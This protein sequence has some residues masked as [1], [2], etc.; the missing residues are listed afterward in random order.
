MKALNFNEW[1][2]V[3]EAIIDWKEDG[4]IEQFYRDAS[5][6]LDLYG[7]QADVSYLELEDLQG[8]GERYDVEVVDFETFY[9]ELPEEMKR[10]A[11]P[12]NRLKLFALGNPVTSRPRIVIQT[13]KLKEIDRET[14]DFIYHM[15]KHEIIH[16]GQINR[17]GPDTSYNLPD[18]N[19]PKE[20]FSDKNEVMAWSHSI[21]DMLISAG[22]A[23]T[24]EDAI[25]NLGKV[26]MYKTIKKNVDEKTLRRYHKYIYLYLQQEL[27][28]E[29]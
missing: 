15:L 1:N 29:D 17:L 9:E 13:K 6:L 20:Y 5:R 14:L 7:E 25:K 8:I 22:K 26:P 24:I 12:P 27:S 16:I 4:T 28:R 11:P 19:N 23:D 2:S 3:N 21:T 10:T 18:L